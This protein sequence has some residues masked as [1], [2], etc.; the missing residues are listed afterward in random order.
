MNCGRA[1][2]TVR[3][4]MNVENKEQKTKNKAYGCS[5]FSVLCSSCRSRAWVQRRFD[6]ARERVDLAGLDGVTQ[7]DA[8]ERVQSRGDV[9]AL[10][11]Q[12]VREL[13]D[14]VHQL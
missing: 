9:L 4:F 1:P 14:L 11:G 6:V 2:T 7:V 8:G 12:V 10:A 3:S 13:V 5:S